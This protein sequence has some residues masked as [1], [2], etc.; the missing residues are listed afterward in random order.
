MAGT[1]TSQGS[2]DEGH[3]QDAPRTIAGD[4]GPEAAPSTSIGDHQRDSGLDLGCSFQRRSSVDHP[5]LAL[6]RR[7]LAA[8][9]LEKICTSGQDL[10]PAS[11][12]PSSSRHR[13]RMPA[14]SVRNPTATCVST[15]LSPQRRACFLRTC[16]GRQAPQTRLLARQ[17]HPPRMLAN[18][19]ATS[20]GR[21]ITGTLL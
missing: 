7:Q 12:H 14:A 17:Y 21:G 13:R 16:H 9:S 2:E 1:Q 19:P 6:F 15:R 8:R 20:Q 11:R 18:D 5:S 10:A 4:C 3:A